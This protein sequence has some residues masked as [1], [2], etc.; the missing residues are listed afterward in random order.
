MKQVYFSTIKKKENDIIYEIFSLACSIYTAIQRDKTV[1][2]VDSDQFDLEYL[3]QCLKKYRIRVLEKEALMYTL[4]AV[5]Y[6]K[7]D[8]V[9]DLTEKVPP[10]STGSFNQIRGDPCPNELKELFMCYHINGIEYT[11]TYKENH[12]EL[13]LFDAY[14]AEY[15]HDYFWLD[16]VNLVVFQ[17]ILKNIHVK[18]V[19]PSEICH[20]IHVL[21]P[22][23]I[24][25]YANLLD[26]PHENYY[27]TLIRKYIEIMTLFIRSTTEPIV[28]VQKNIH[29][30]LESYMKERGNPFLTLDLQETSTFTEITKATG[31]FV[32]NFNMDSLTGSACSYYLHH[33]IP[34]SQSILIDLSMIYEK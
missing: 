4:V 27:E 1:V 22:E 9:I 29:P 18:D 26:K 16:K 2:I 23:D 33:L 6:G 7:G 13:V 32:G 11:D 10:L 28:L 15:T 30:L 25:P 14:Q 21:N 5:F 12:T 19:S 31:I 8:K 24:L 17:D 34:S 20:V 3:T